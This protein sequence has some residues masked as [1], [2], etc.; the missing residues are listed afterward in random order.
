[1]VL[2]PIVAAICTAA[3]AL[4]LSG[5]GMSPEP[6]GKTFRVLQMNLCNSGI[7]GC[8]SGRSVNEAGRVIRDTAPDVVTL[9]EVCDADV[10]ALARVM[11]DVHGRAIASAFL[12]APDRRTGGATK[13]LNGGDFGVGM[14]VLTPTPA[15][16]SGGIYPIQDVKDP[17]VRVWLCLQASGYDA[18]ATH[19]ASTDA[20]VAL[21]QCQYLLGSAI[22][23]F[24]HFDGYQPA[25]LGGDFNLKSGNTPDVR[26]CI[27]A[28]Y[29]HY[30]DGDVQHIL[31]T[32]PFTSGSIASMD[33]NGATDHPGLLVTATM[34]RKPP[35]SCII[36]PVCR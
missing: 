33:L 16:T 29:L 14:L 35:S 11:A 10:E 26:P 28:G 25:V 17:E 27:P 30:G 23:D 6:A 12:A 8:Y 22:P 3:A 2:R 20:A 15:R 4:L 31:M 18:C 36:G 9:N 24:R 5:S 19:L 13:C 7:A 32:S 1:M 21:A 34:P